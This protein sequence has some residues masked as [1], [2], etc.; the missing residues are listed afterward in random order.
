MTSVIPVSKSLGSSLCFYFLAR[1]FI[2]LAQAR[3]MVGLLAL[4]RRCNVK[5]LLWLCCAVFHLFVCVDRVKCVR[6]IAPYLFAIHWM[7]INWSLPDVIFLCDTP[8]HCLL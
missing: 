3:L 1:G 5:M 6:W 7:K 2:S 8:A 4:R